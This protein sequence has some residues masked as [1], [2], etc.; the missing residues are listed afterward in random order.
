MELKAQF[1]EFLRDIRPTDRQ[2][3]NWKTGSNTLRSRLAADEKLNE[4]VVAT[5]LQGS[6]R[7]ST[8]IRPT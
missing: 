3:E 7:R 5:F 2:K 8:A 1:N 4:I 6:V